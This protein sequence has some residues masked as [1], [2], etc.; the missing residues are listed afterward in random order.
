MKAGTGVAFVCDIAGQPSCHS[1]SSENGRS[2]KMVLNYCYNIIIIVTGGEGAG[3]IRIRTTLPFS[4]H[5][6]FGLIVRF[7]N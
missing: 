6:L 3:S 5:L 2:A 1:S 7:V 4:T